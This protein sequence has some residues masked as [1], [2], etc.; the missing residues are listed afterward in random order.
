MKK[1]FHSLFILVAIVLPGLL[2][3][4]DDAKAKRPDNIG[5]SDFDS[6]KNTSFDILDESTSLKTDAT[7]IDSE[8]KNYAA[9][10]S[11]VTLDKLKT[12]FKALKGIGE[13]SKALTTKIGDLDNQGKELLTS[14]K[15]V[16]PKTKSPQASGITNKSVKGLES[17]RK[18][19]D[20]VTTLVQDNTKLLA[21]ELKNRGE[22][23]E[24]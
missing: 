4:Q 23:V 8:V 15:N 20:V 6:F 12:D 21:A 2:V 1:Y 5:V 9:T 22:A 17:A 10:I 13:S 11:T 7:R 14:A 3:A 24:D 16:T 18:N 19:L